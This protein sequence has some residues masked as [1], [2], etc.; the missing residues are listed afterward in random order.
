MSF[1]DEH[2]YESKERRRG[3]T[4]RFSKNVVISGVAGTL[5]GATLFAFAVPTFSRLNPPRN[6][7]QVQVKT[8]EVKSYTAPLTQNVASSTED[9]RSGFVSAV[10]KASEAVVGV[11]NIQRD[12]FSEEDAEAG[13][14]SGVIY[15]KANGKAYVVTNH[16]V[17]EGA[18]RIEISLSDGKK[19]PADILGSDVV[20]DLA[21]LQMDEKYAAKVI[22]IGDST[23]VQR[24]EPAIAIGNPLGLEF[25]GTVTQ[26]IISATERILPVDLDNDGHYDWQVEVLQTDAAIN[27]GNSGGA[28]VNVDGKLI[29]INSMKIATE[30]V[31]GI[32]LAIPISR[33]VPI[34]QELE[35]TGKV[36][37][38][39][40]GVELR[41]LNE[42]PTYYWEKTLQL[43]TNVTSGV[44]VLD[45]KS[46]SPASREGM[47]EYDVIVEVDGKPVHDII[48]FR[49]ILYS[50][51]INDTMK[52]V[53][54]RGSEQKT[55]TVKLAEENY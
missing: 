32:G 22:E 44:C 13:T 39:Y 11:I 40:L 37:R 8:S 38:P 35:K 24:G 12:S 2:E 21:V 30:A 53:F 29:G 36:K 48:E 18:N 16:H 50:K 26:G 45:V 55:A 6:E 46:P 20:T 14:G 52:I 1:F 7:G 31:E 4:G 10:D 43:P 5:V 51:K 42:I 54:Y 17:V 15:K 9:I 33:A 28:L 3:K 23:K 41:S 47:H 19:V 34:I 27:P 49:T 25:S